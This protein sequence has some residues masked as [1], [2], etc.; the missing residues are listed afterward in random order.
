MT[1]KRRQK[2]MRRHSP[3]NERIKRRYFVYLA[4]ANRYS[5]SSVDAVAKALSRFETYNKY[6]DFKTFHFQQAV[7]FKNHLAVQQ[8]EATGRKLSKAT[9]S[10]T[11][12]HLKRFFH[13][14]A[15]QPGFKSFL[16][17]SDAEYF[18]LSEKD[19]RQGQTRQAGADIGAN[20]TCHRCDAIRLRH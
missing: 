6:R 5:E 18:N 8:S 17:Y 9:L 3:V 4:E 1:S 13:W 15:G 20:H 12:S 16:Q 14:L 7:G 10:A 19:S 11:L 2:T